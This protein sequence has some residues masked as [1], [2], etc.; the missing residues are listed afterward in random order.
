MTPKA[1]RPSSHPCTHAEGSEGALLLAVVTE[2]QLER[3]CRGPAHVLGRRESACRARG[4][5]GEAGAVRG[6]TWRQG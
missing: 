2:E 4:E 6:L 5:A 3:F 1:P